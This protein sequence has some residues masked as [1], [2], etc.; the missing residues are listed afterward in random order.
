MTPLVFPAPSTT[1]EVG[2]MAEETNGKTSS[3]SE[4]TRIYLTVGVVVTI[5]GMLIAGAFTA[6]AVWRD[7]GALQKADVAHEVQLADHEARMRAIETGI[8]DV[9]RGQEE[10]AGTQRAVLAE[11]KLSTVTL[12]ELRVALAAKGIVL[13]GGG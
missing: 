8:R 12:N 3:I 11:A 2:A 4:K 6:G 10:A 13:K 9:L 1:S 7:F 5:A